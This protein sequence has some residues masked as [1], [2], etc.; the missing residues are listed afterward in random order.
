MLTPGYIS[1]IHLSIKHCDTPLTLPASSTA[2]SYVNLLCG[3]PP[4]SCLVID[5]LLSKMTSPKKQQNTCKQVKD[6][7]R[8]K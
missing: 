1:F 5:V 4:A 6:E 7:Y 8:S 2:S 3:L